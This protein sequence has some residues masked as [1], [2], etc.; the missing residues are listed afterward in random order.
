MFL[1]TTERHKKRKFRLGTSI[2]GNFSFF[3]FIFRFFRIFFCFSFFSF[4]LF[5]FIYKYGCEAIKDGKKKFFFCF[6]FSD[7]VFFGKINSCEMLKCEGGGS[8]GFSELDNRVFAGAENPFPGNSLFFVRSCG[9]FVE[10]YCV[11]R[12]FS[13][14]ESWVRSLLAGFVGR[15]LKLRPKKWV[16]KVN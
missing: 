12:N 11:G 10:A 13:E 5:H 2:R 7:Y 9:V 15:N 14:G 4:F 8:M 3:L 16:Q 6:C 1:S